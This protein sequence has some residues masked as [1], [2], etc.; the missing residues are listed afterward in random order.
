M[1]CFRDNIYGSLITA[2][3]YIWEILKENCYSKVQFCLL[4]AHANDVVAMKP[5]FRKASVVV[6]HT[7]VSSLFFFF[8]MQ[9]NSESNSSCFRRQLTKPVWETLCSR[10]CVVCFLISLA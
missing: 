9:L 7:Q 5:C 6:P 4:L 8:L 3:I 1:P 10:H 2:N